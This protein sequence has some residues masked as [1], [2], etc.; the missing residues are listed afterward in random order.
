MNCSTKEEFNS[1]IEFGKAINDIRSDQTSDTTIQFLDTSQ[2]LVS[3]IEGRYS[4]GGTATIGQS[5]TE[6]VGKKFKYFRK[7]PLLEQQGEIGDQ[8][9]EL[10]QYVTKEILKVTDEKSNEAAYQYVKNLP[11]FPRE[12]LKKIYQDYGK[13]LDTKSEQ[14]LIEGVQQNLLS[15]YRIQRTLNKLS[16]KD[17]KVQIRTEQVIIDPKRDLGGTIDF[18][19]IFS[20]NTAAVIDYKTKIIPKSNLDAFGNILNGDKVVSTRDIDKYKLQTGEYGRI[21]RES[22]GVKSIRNVTILPI[23]LVVSLDT[24]LNKYG[25]KIEGLTFPGQDIL[26]E[27]ILPFSNQTGFK[28]LDEFI[29]SVDT[30]IDRLKQRIKAN[31]KLREDLQDRINNLERSKKDILIN[32][33]LD[34]VL[35]YGKSL[36]EKVKKANLGELSIAEIQ[37][38]RDELELLASITK[39]T[40]EYRQFLKGVDQS[41]LD[42]FDEKAGSIT[43]ELEETIEDLKSVLFENKITKLIEIHTGF[44]ITDDYGNIVPFAQEGYFGKWYYQL[45]QFDNPIFK[46][47]RS[48][49]DQVNYKVRQRT[50][51]VVEDIVQT[52]NEVYNWLK[53]T[54]RTFEDL[55]QIMINPNTDN[56]WGKYS[57]KFADILNSLPGEDLH[58]HYEPGEGYTESYQQ[59]M[60][61]KLQFFKDE[62]FT[63][64]E[65]EN[66]I[67]YWISQNDLSVING[68]ASYP[69][70]WQMAK[71]Y[72]RLHLK[73]SPEDYNH[74]YKFILSVPQLKNYYEMFEKYNKEFRQLLGVDYNRLPN[75]FL[76]NVRKTMS[77]RVT[78]DGFSGFLDGTQD[79]LRDFSIREEDRSEDSTYNSNEQI[80]IF[81]LNRFRNEDRSLNVG[82]KS[83]QFGRSLAIFAKMAYNYEAVTER[84]AEILALQQFLSQEAEQ[85]LQSRGKN[86][87]DQ[88]GNTITE[89]LQATDIPE[90]FQSFVD[91]Y[92][93][94]I[95]VK[96]IIGDRSGTAEKMLLKAKEYFTLKTLGFNVI[97][98]L[99]S[100]MSAKINTLIEANKGII[101]NRTNYK[102]SLTASWT[103]REKFLAMNAFFDPMSHRLNHP[104]LAGETKYGERFYSDP[105]MRGWVNKYVNSRMLMN[106]FS[107]GDQYIE[108]LV[109]VAMSKNYYVDNLGNLRKIKFDSDLE[110]HKDRLIWDL[111]SYS[112][113]SGAKL[114]LTE[115]QIAKVFEDF[116]R[117]VQAGQSRIKGTIPDEDKAH[118]QN[119]IIMQLVMH[120]KSWMPGILFERFGKVKY[121]SRIDSLYMG[122]Y[123]SLSKEFQNPDKLVFKEFFKKILIPRL[124]KLAA[125]VVTFG[126][127]SKSRLNDKHNKLLYFEK[128]LDENPQYKN[129]VTF[130]EFLH[131]QQVQLKSVIQELRVL[132]TI[133]GLL[134]L[135]GGDFDDDGQRDYKKYLL[136][137][138]LASLLFKTQQE[139]SFT[140]SPV[141]FAGMIK[142]PL[143]MLSLVTDAWKTIANTIDEILDIPFGEDRLIGGTKGK[144]KQPI[145]Y[146]THKWFPGLGGAMRFFDAF[147]DDTQYEKT[148]QQ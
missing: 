43:L 3:K 29:R 124:G 141:A 78:A 42:S 6:K 101:F 118:W 45:S 61:D 34:T 18:L 2:G 130:E 75:N 40:H 67:N 142:S 70:A 68:K 24:N 66:K 20:D 146:N 114:D 41:K 144:D 96:S 8:I 122:K 87:I 51:Q 139:L 56:F 27:K 135:L 97:A 117:A 110:T 50:D 88:M 11:L 30:Q 108:E 105:T 98:G 121:D 12:G 39:S 35:D 126:M 112:K 65:L 131:V 138:K 44:K 85:I 9:H 57:Q 4:A 128:W 74:N 72:N 106:T 109:L 103:D 46:S 113:E 129:K 92:V 104:R 13:T 123:T 54:G 33:N 49:L 143:P 115:E 120:F 125:D 76:P 52:E 37:D 28:S 148:T 94:K 86:M 83:Y 82:E 5:V 89:K 127:L 77:E 64:K 119:N 48:I 47:L 21:L 38:L 25:N 69:E 19:A 17:G 147:N 60:L 32:H 14:N 137:R 62:G 136:T 16:G 23:K 15:V 90:I 31:P 63:G 55:I 111:F 102:E 84:H 7:N 36:A 71:N 99:G 145:L 26:L 132:L 58:K 73:D 134:V 81:F 116:R 133:A 1:A 22:Y 59:R 93:Y 91:M 107:V 80:P 95:G 79:F 53:Q 10:N 100:L 140:Y